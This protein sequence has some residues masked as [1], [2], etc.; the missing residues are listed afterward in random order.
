MHYSFLKTLC[1]NYTNT[2]T[3]RLE[4]MCRNH[5][6]FYSFNGSKTVK[7]KFLN[8]QWN[9]DFTESVRG[10]S[11]WRTMRVSETNYMT[12]RYYRKLLYFMILF[13]FWG[14]AFKGTKLIKAYFV[15]TLLNLIN[16]LMGFLMV[17]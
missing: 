17:T 7:D 3:I 10:R 8:L 2:Q 14:G 11:L 13:I 1:G 5:L 15:V 16:G 4:N 9:R 12:F 6:Y